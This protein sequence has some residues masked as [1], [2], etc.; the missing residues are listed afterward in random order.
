MSLGGKADLSYSRGSHNLKFGAQ[1]MQTR[2]AEAFQLGVTD[3]TFNPVCLTAGGDPVTDP[4]LVDPNA[5]SKAGFQANPD[6]DV[7][8]NVCY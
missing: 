7:A 8:C 4:R 2:L 1:I 5:C 3:P 6:D